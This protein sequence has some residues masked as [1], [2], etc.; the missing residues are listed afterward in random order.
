MLPSRKTGSTT[1][2]AIRRSYLAP[3]RN[4]S[5]KF[6]PSGCG[7]IRKKITLLILIRMKKKKAVEEVHLISAGIRNRC[8]LRI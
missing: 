2:H 1:I 8:M 4:A 6:S 3:R 5:V 7:N